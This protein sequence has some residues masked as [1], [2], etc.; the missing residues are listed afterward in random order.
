MDNMLN[1]MDLIKV[2][3]DID[4]GKLELNIKE[5]VY[6]YELI[7]SITMLIRALVGFLEEENESEQDN[8]T[9]DLIFEFLRE[10]YETDYFN[11]AEKYD[12]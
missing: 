2:F 1:N 9:L 12:A 5:G 4:T 3:K 10:K 8:I 6:G 11:I 7:N